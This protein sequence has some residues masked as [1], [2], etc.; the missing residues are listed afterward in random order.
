MQEQENAVQLRLFQDTM[1]VISPV[2]T[3]LRPT[4]NRQ[5]ELRSVGKT[6]AEFFAGIGLVRLGLEDEGWVS[7]FANDIDPDLS[8]PGFDLT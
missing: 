8:L 1:P 3:P 2:E 4:K 5:N 7:K 6:F